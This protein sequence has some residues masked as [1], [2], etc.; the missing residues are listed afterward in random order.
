[1]NSDNPCSPYRGQAARA[2]GL[3]DPA[4]YRILVKG[5]LDA[6]WS[7][8]F[9]N[10]AIEADRARGETAICGRLAD[11]AALH[12]LLNKVGNLGL[13]LLDVTFLASDTPAGTD[14]SA[15]SIGPDSRP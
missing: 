10:L 11:Q 15:L 3:A 12:G 7:E 13:V 2:I 9:D 4:S 6:S 14:S 5:C 1:M 8:W